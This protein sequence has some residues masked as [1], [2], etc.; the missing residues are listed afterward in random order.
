MAPVAVSDEAVIAV[1]AEVCQSHV[2]GRGDASN[3]SNGWAQDTLAPVVC[4]YISFESM[5]IV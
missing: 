2:L 1:V 3:F 5:F 4:L